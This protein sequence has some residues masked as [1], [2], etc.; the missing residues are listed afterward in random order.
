M[1]NPLT[2][3]ERRGL[4]AV[5]AAAL[6]C[7]ASGFAFRNCSSRKPASGATVTI[8]DEESVTGVRLDSASKDSISRKDRKNNKSESGNGKRS[9]RLKRQKSSSERNYPTRSPLDEPIHN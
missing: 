5:A 1:K 4:M 8:V 6:L 2:S 9:R 7:I 3:K